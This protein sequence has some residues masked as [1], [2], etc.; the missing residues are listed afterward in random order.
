M[1]MREQGRFFDG[2]RELKQAE[3]IFSDPFVGMIVH[4]S[5]GS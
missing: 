4:I 3:F 5:A 2:K 1:I